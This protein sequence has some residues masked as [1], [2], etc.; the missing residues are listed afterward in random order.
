MLTFVPRTSKIPVG[1]HS[2]DTFIMA[3]ATFVKTVPF[4]LLASPSTYSAA[5]FDYLDPSNKITALEWIEVFRKSLPTF[6]AHALEDEGM[7]ASE[8]KE[9][10]EMFATEFNDILDKL[11]DDPTAA[12]P[13]HDAQPLSC[14]SLCRVRDKCLH[15]AG[16]KDIFK[17]VKDKE[18]TSALQLLPGV[19]EELDA[20]NNV[21]AS[22]DKALRGTF[23]GN[24]FDMGAAA[25]ADRY[26]SGELSFT[27]TREGL[28]PRPWAVDDFDAALDALA[29]PRPF[30]RALLFCDNAGPDVLLGMLPFAREL[31]KRGTQVVLAANSVPSI[32]D[33]TAEEL[34]PLLAAAAE[35]D[36]VIAA[37]LFNGALTVVASGND[38]GVIDLSSVS[39][40][41]AEAC[42]GVDLVVLEGM[43]RGIET[44]LYA[45]FSVAA[46]RIALIKHPEVATMLG[47][48]LYDVVCRFEPGPGASNN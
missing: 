37:A 29:A 18:N 44:N 4:P 47:G 13:G 21:R 46:L 34:L 31:V 32:N 7:V 38:L 35:R 43:G 24:I 23:A 20:E 2:A 48:R 5:T 1:E 30:A 26:E 14:V 28:L 6:R 42:E 41:L 22:F 25:S 15:N 12:I 19:L 16:F 8:R 27:A 9:K 45:S 33:I 36:E 11:K 39:P 40:E 17:Y 3:V 10:A